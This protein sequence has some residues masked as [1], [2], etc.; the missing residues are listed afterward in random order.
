MSELTYRHAFI[1]GLTMRMVQ[2]KFAP[3][4]S[5]LVLL[6]EFSSEM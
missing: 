6:A 5:E 1:V 4:I 2:V 3:G